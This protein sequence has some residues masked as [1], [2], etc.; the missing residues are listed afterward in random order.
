[1]MRL[2]IRAGLASAVLFTLAGALVA[3]PVPAAADGPASM[4]GFTP[5]GA[6]RQQ[7]L[8]RKFDALLS[9]GELRDWLQRLSSEPNQ[10]GSPHDKANAEWML[11]Q[12]RQWGWD[13]HIEKFEVL[14]PEPKQELVELVAPTH[15]KATLHEPPIK[16]DRSSTLSG[17]LPPYNIY[18]ADGDVTGELVYVNY[19][20]PDDYKELARLGVS[21]KGKIVIVRYG[22]GWRGLKPELAHEH[23]AIGCLI[24]SDP[25]ND[26]YF[27]GDTYPEGPTRPAEGVQR[28]SVMKMQLHPGDPTTPGY[29]SV[30]GAKHLAVKDARTVL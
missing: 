29:G 16:G 1:M 6:A 23:G 22:G 24:Y 5:A 20:M 9:A 7:Q 15:F 14:N 4:L 18:G 30:P 26:G 2:K 25:R 21:V 17:A 10:V 11:A 27:N 8:E 13:A 28:G 19:G 3:P 12:F